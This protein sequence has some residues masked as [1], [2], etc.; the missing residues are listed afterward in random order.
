MARIISICRSALNRAGSCSL[1]DKGV[2][3][4]EIDIVVR[5]ALGKTC[6]IVEAAQSDDAINQLWIAEGKIHGMIRAKA[7]ASRNQKGIGVM[8]RVNGRTSFRR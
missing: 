1:L 2:G 8:L 3:V 4:V 5:E 6:D 7:R